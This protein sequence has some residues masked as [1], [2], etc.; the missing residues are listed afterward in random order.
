[1]SVHPSARPSKAPRG[2]IGLV[3]DPARSLQQIVIRWAVS[4]RAIA[5]MAPQGSSAIIHLVL[6]LDQLGRMQW[7]LVDPKMGNEQPLDLPPDTRSASITHASAAL[8]IEAPGLCCQLR[9][10]KHNSYELVYARTD[11]FAMLNVPGGRYEPIDCT[12]DEDFSQTIKN[13]SS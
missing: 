5:K 2:P 1:M 10:G 7:A 4:R 12:V 6:R 11:R 9:P 8:H 13:P 3:G